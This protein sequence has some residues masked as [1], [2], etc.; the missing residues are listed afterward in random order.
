[1]NNQ[2]NRHRAIAIASSIVLHALLLWLLWV[3]TKVVP[4]EH[5][6]PEQLVVM[7]WPIAV[8]PTFPETIIQLATSSKPQNEVASP[9]QPQAK[10][11][12]TPPMAQIPATRPKVE[13]PANVLNT[14]VTATPESSNFAGDYAPYNSAPGTNELGLN[15][16]AV[17]LGLSVKTRDD[18]KAVAEMMAIEQK[19]S[20]NK[21]PTEVCVGACVFHVDPEGNERFDTVNFDDMAGPLL[22]NWEA[23]RFGSE[24]KACLV[25]EKNHTRQAQQL[26]CEPYR[27]R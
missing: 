13:L 12:R 11:K 4:A 26:L 17:K 23:A 21:R 22:R 14:D 15:A 1:V 5:P 6:K 20:K 24:Y 2:G 27:S 18:E 10:P 19:Y 8:N 7:T 9:I 16:D 25:R 3:A